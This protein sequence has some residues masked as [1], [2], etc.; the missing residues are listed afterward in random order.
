MLLAFA[1]ATIVVSERFS[2]VSLTQ[3]LSMRV[4][5]QNFVIFLS[6]VFV[7]HRIFSAFGLYASR[8]LSIRK[9]EVLDII[10]STSL[11]TFFIL[12]ASALFHIRMVTGEFVLVFWAMSTLSA[13]A[14]RIVLRLVLKQIRLHGRNLRDMLI[15]GTND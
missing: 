1:L 13:V 14:S 6:L 9:D 7:W 10:K 8:R 5:I 2:A 3:F 4:K 15:V 11:G 12:L